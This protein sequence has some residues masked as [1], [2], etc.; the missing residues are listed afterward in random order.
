MSGCS[1]T[2][3]AALTDV[4]S[5]ATAQSCPNT[6]GPRLGGGFDQHQATPWGRHS[7]RQLTHGAP[8]YG[9]EAAPE[10][11]DG[12]AAERQDPTGSL[13]QRGTT[14]QNEPEQQQRR[15]RVAVNCAPAFYRLPGRSVAIPEIGI[16]T[17][18]A[19]IDT[20]VIIS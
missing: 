6:F 2:R 8:P 14:G 16:N 17:L 1:T 4:Q 10:E 9:N 15:T 18:T 3:E 19:A 13:R 11:D 12:A 5:E 7:H 20:M